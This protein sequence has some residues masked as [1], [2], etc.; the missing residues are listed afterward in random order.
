MEGVLTLEDVDLKG[1]TVLYRVDV[2]SPLEPSSGRLLDDGRLRG[3]VPT[4]QALEQSK[5]V[6]MGH[7][8]R[9]GKSD[10]T[11]MS[12]HCDRLSEILGRPIKF[13]PDVCG[14]QAIEEI[15]NMSDGDVIFLD[16]VRGNEEE[17]GVKYGSNE[18]TEDTDIVTTLSSVSDAFVTDAFAAAH[19][20]SP[21]LT[22]FTKSIPC[23]AGT[24]MEKEISSLR[25]ALKD[26]P[27]PYLAILGGAKCDD[28]V[29][30]ALNLISKGEVD[31][32]AF[33]G[34]TGNLMLWIDG[35]DIGERNRDF[36]RNSL[37]DD[38][39]IA[40]EM[41]ERILSEHPD[42]AFLPIDVA[43]ESDGRRKPL[44]IEDLPSEDPIYDVGIETLRALKPLVED[45]G[46]IL[47][48]GPASYFELPEFAFG[49]IEILNMCTEANAMTIIG[50]GH[51]SALVNSRGAANLV[52]HNSTGGGST[53]SFLSG[54]PMPVIASLKES[55]RKHSDDLGSLGLA[56]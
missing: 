42:K 9:P 37:G 5:V 55:C 4:L 34:V 56:R 15:E 7:Q 45:A 11:S 31:R 53:M 3:V 8:S 36:I 22:G 29:R 16:N 2:N 35:N 20:R 41:A 40:W 23:I 33:V 24:L 43:V 1:R 12:R 32:I 26:P 14:V 50:G 48:N 17:Y 6:I 18:D 30:V 54:E 44:S 52:S 27:S 46:C 49:T 38:F 21:T 39:E 10:F 47:W 25:M 28:S 19:R 13:V 51:T